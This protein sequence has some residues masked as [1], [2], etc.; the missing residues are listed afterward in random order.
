MRVSTYSGSIL[1]FIVIYA[2]DRGG[3]RMQRRNWLIPQLSLKDVIVV[4]TLLEFGTARAN[5][6]GYCL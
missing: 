2:Y 5:K 4:A 3:F 6:K 1:T